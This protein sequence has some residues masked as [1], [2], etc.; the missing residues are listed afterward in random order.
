MPWPPGLFPAR[1]C[2]FF[3]GARHTVKA[4][5]RRFTMLEVVPE[6]VRYYIDILDQIGNIPDHRRNYRVVQQPNQRPSIVHAY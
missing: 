6:P 3:I 4:T 5:A 1:I 2:R